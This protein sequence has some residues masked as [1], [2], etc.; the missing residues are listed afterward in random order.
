MAEPGAWYACLPLETVYSFEP[1]P[2][3]QQIGGGVAA[4]ADEATKRAGAS[5]GGATADSAAPEAAAPSASAKD[6]AAEEELNA[7]HASRA[8][9]MEESEPGVLLACASPMAVEEEALEGPADGEEGP[10]RC[11]LAGPG[12]L[13]FVQGVRA[14]AC[15]DGGPRHPLPPLCAIRGHTWPGLCTLRGRRLGPSMQHEVRPPGLPLHLDA[16]LLTDEEAA[17]V[18]GGQ[19]NLWTEYVGDADT[20]EY[21]LLPRL[22][23]MA[24]V[25][26]SPREARDWGSFRQRLAPMVS[27]LEALGYNVRRL[28]A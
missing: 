17:H 27:H 9:T 24:E 25:M 12:G 5:S 18:L 26:W 3:S 6:A 21:M 8:C 14:Q 4:G 1:V 15:T 13:G 19:A 10:S 11:A 22:C 2:Q 28:D 16:R 7:V 23:A 20:A